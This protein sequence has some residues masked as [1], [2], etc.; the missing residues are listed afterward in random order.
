MRKSSE[1][2]NDI[3]VNVTGYRD[4]SHIHSTD[5]IGAFVLGKSPPFT[6]N[7][8]FRAG[9]RLDTSDEK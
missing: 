7:R 2:L 4:Y 8:G 1:A 5:P 3:G 6:T 9:F